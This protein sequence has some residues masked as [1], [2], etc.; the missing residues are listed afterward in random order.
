VYVL[1]P[2][3]PPL[4]NDTYESCGEMEKQMATNV[5]NG[6][7]GCLGFVKENYDNA[8]AREP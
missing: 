6:M 3:K 8:K 4:I 7:G 5:D 1:V 2:S